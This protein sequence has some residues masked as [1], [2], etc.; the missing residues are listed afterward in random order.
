MQRCL[1]C[2]ATMTPKETTCP[3]CGS[4]SKPK[5]EKGGF[6]SRFRTAVKIFFLLSAVLSVVA[7]FT[8]YGPPF[9]TC[10]S[11][12]LVLLLVKSSADEMLVD[13]E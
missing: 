3:N 1:Q 8:D 12:T 2:E 9:L 10:V 6:K 4:A 13:G 5:S 7:L 11:V